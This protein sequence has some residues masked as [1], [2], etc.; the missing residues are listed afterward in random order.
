MQNMLEK[1]IGKSKA[2]ERAIAGEDLNAQDGIELMESDDHY[3]IGAVADATR[4]KLVGDKVT[5]TA[6]S[7]LNYTLS[8]IHI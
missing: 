5:F 8:L 7:Y 2:L 4:K 3:M 6:S 1:L